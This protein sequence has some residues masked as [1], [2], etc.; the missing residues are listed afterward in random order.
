MAASSAACP[1]ATALGERSPYFAW[2][3]PATT[4]RWQ[5]RYSVSDKL[6]GLKRSSELSVGTAQLGLP[7]RRI[8]GIH[9]FATQDP[10]PPRRSQIA[11][12]IRSLGTSGE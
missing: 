11:S 2:V 7:L 8:G 10:S 1:I 9:K 12:N 6:G 5:G 4:T 3:R